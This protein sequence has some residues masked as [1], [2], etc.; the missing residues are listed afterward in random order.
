MDPWEPMV[1]Q[2]LLVLPWSLVSFSSAFQCSPSGPTL[3]VFLSRFFLRSVSQEF[4]RVSTQHGRHSCPD[5][6]V[7]SRRCCRRWFSESG[8]VHP[9]DRHLNV[10]KREKKRKAVF[11]VGMIINGDVGVKNHCHDR[12]L[13]AAEYYT[14]VSSWNPNQSNLFDQ[15]KIK[16]RIQCLQ[17]GNGNDTDEV[18]HWSSSEAGWLGFF[19]TKNF[20]PTPFRDAA[21]ESVVIKGSASHFVGCLFFFEQ[22]GFLW[23]FR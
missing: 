2:V 20:V 6:V 11:N 3:D 7:Y 17:D 23:S 12:L 9:S 15:P 13:R 5:E 4:Q 16:K 22:G 14:R 19:F 18:F 1:P 21:R 8:R 10:K